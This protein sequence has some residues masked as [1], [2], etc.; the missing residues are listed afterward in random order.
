L[1]KEQD[2]GALSRSQAEA[3]N[4]VSDSASS[5]S[6]D[7]STTAS[8]NGN[9]S[10][11]QSVHGIS[12]SSADN[13]QS[14]PRARQG[15]STLQDPTLELQAGSQNQRPQVLTRV[16]Q[17]HLRELP[18]IDVMQAEMWPRL[19]GGAKRKQR[20]LVLGRP[21]F[22][23]CTMWVVPNTLRFGAMDAVVE[24]NPLCS[25]L[26]SPSFF[27]LLFSKLSIFVNAMYV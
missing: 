20:W 7:V 13:S 21:R 26:I 19:L 12:N 14:T 27:F 11:L 18:G 15:N 4:P 10:S 24:S 1:P 17:G 23:T 5:T 9:S 6:S 8:L 16:S 25:F 3:N 2:S 22:M